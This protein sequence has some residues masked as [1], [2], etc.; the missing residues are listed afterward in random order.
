VFRHVLLPAL[1]L[2]LH[3]TVLPSSK[4]LCMYLHCCS[5]LQCSRSGQQSG[6]LHDDSW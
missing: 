5:R 2:L 1:L 3:L 4:Q 6:Q